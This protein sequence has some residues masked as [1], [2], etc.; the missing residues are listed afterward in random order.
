MSSKG[1]NGK[2]KSGGGG[3]GKA[4]GVPS[5]RVTRNNGMV[6]DVGQRSVS[7]PRG[8]NVVLANS[9][10]NTESVNNFLASDLAEFNA[11]GPGLQVQN[12][13]LRELGYISDEEGILD[14]EESGNV[15]S[16]E[17]KVEEEADRLREL[18]E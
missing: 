11:S 5:D 18:L 12:E 4:P 2:G 15:S 16:D 7:V 8:S 3:V 1:V 17:G 9:L 10:A 13:L 6:G 14:E